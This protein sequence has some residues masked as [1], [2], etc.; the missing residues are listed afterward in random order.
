MKSSFNW[1][2]QYANAL[3]N[4]KKVKVKPVP[5]VS[6]LSVSP[7]GV[8]RLKFTEPMINPPLELIRNVTVEDK[9]TK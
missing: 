6:I 3:L 8:V 2:E 5:D 1:G 9:A 7:S 4:G